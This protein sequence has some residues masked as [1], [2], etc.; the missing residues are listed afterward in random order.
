MDFDKCLINKFILGGVYVI[1]GMTWAGNLGGGLCVLPR[2]YTAF[3]VN[4]QRSNIQSSSLSQYFPLYEYPD[5]APGIRLFHSLHDISDSA[6]QGSCL[7]YSWSPG[8]VIARGR[9]K[10]S[11]ACL[12]DQATIHGI[13]ISSLIRCN[14][15]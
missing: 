8:G 7:A 3:F 12:I 10:F 15:N 4:A 2:D 5:Q 9:Y 1:D 13:T 14:I 11:Y 6:I